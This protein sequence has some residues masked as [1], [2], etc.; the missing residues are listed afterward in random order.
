MNHGEILFIYKLAREKSSSKIL[1]NAP[2]HRRKLSKATRT[3]KP[4]NSLSQELRKFIFPRRIT[5]FPLFLSNSGFFSPFQS[6][7]RFD[8]RLS[9]TWIANLRLLHLNSR[10]HRHHRRRRSSRH[11]PLRRRRHS[12]TRQTPSST[13]RTRRRP[14]R[15]WSSMCRSLRQNSG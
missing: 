15:L 9:S 1:R 11:R 7:E 5:M 2:H 14:R 4:H 8:L 13:N 3:Q 6:S 12:S 10:R